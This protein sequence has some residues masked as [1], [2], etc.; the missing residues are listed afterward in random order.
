MV[1]LVA[2]FNLY[3]LRI[4]VVLNVKAMLGSMNGLGDK[5]IK[6]EECMKDV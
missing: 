5:L 1:M 4:C 3:V 2:K 6:M